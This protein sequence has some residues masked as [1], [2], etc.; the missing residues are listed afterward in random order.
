MDKPTKIIIISDSHGDRGALASVLATEQDADALIFLGDG[1]SDLAA[2]RASCRCPMVYEV[3]GNCDYD[4]SVPPERLVAFE[5][6]LLF[7]THG[8]GYEVKATLGPLLRA[9][10]QREADIVLF[11]HTHTPHLEQVEGIWVFNPGSVSI[12]RTRR[13]SYG[14]LT[15]TNGVPQFAHREVKGR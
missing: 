3:R 13:P 2:V 7:F 10:K 11:G 14:I 6:L 1:L 5:N 9:A 12:P 15:I 8:H 4:K